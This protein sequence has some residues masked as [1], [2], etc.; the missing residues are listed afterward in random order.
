[1]KSCLAAIR[2][3]GAVKALAHITGGGFPD[4]I[5]RV[6]PKG[7]GVAHR[8][9]R[10]CRCCRCSSGWRQTGDVAEREMLRTF[11]CG[12]GMIAVV[13]A[14]RGR[15]GAAVLARA[16][17]DRRCDSARSSPAHGD[18]RV[19]L[20]RRA[21]SRAVTG[22]ARKRVAILISGR[23]SNMAA[24]IE[25]A[26][27]ADYPGRD[28]ARALEPARRRRACERAAAAGIATAV[29]DHAAF[30]KDREASSARCR[31]CSSEHRIELVCLA[32][33]MRLFTP[34]FVGAL[35][36]PDAQHPSGAAAVLQGPRH[37]CAA[38]SRP[39]SKIHGA[40]VHFVMPEMD[41]G[42]IIAQGAVPVL[43]DDT[44]ATLAAR[45]LDVE[46]RIYPLAL[47]LVASGP[48]ADR[49]RPLCDRWATRRRGSRLLSPPIKKTPGRTGGFRN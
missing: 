2:E 45:V 9:R 8:S 36:R 33:F 11:N 38:R 3:T 43:P 23:G 10:A 12:I 14:G 41:A 31:R 19:H 24:L 13:G 46:H 4:N 5:P 29:V 6:L 47:R 15:C 40:T 44:E 1:M 27:D 39:A 49:R 35:A 28:R 18:E 16:R 20:S 30:G 32:G 7:L 37:A 22:M 34:W 48:C 17:R 25:A 21:R 42:P 26:K